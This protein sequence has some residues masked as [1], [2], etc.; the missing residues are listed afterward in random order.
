VRRLLPGAARHPYRRRA[1][2]TNSGAN[3]EDAP[4]L[5][6]DPSLQQVLDAHRSVIF[7]SGRTHIS[8][9]DVMGCVA[10]DGA[11]GSL[12]VND[13]SVAPTALRTP[14]LLA[15]REWVDGAVLRLGIGEKSAE[16]VSQSL[17]SGKKIARGYYRYTRG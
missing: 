12:Y 5:S 3:P 10:Y 13:S 14:G 2:L 7:L 6:R 1:G 16:I 17:S 8:M 11:R 15:D 9:N 4:Y